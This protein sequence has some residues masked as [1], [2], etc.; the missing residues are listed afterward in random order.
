MHYDQRTV[1][2]RGFDALTR[3]RMDFLML[4]KGGARVVIE[5]DGAQHYAD[6]QMRAETER[7]ARMVAADRDLKLSGYEVFRFGADELRADPARPDGQERPRHIVRAF[8]ER[9]FKEYGV[10]MII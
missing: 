10:R 7:Y 6:A 2:E 3:Q 4:L 8:F 1:Q 5:V 9:L